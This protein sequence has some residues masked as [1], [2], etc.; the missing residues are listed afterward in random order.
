MKDSERTEGDG[1]FVLSS[2][3]IGYL[4]V[5]ASHEAHGVAKRD[6]TREAWQS[7][8]DLGDI[9]LAP[10]GV[11]AGRVVGFGEA[12]L[13]HCLVTAT[14]A[15][16]DSDFDWHET[17][18]EDDGS[19]R[20]AALERIAYTIEVDYL[21]RDEV[22]FP[23]VFTPDMEGLV[24]RLAVPSALVTVLGPE[25]VDFMEVELVVKAVERVSANWRQTRE[26]A[27]IVERSSSRDEVFH[28]HFTAPGIFALEARA[29]AGSSTW[30]AFERVEIGPA[31][32]AIDLELVP[33]G[34]QKQRVEV[35]GPDQALTQSWSASFF[36]PMSGAAGGSVTD[37]RP[38]I[39]LPVGSW[40]ATV[41]P[42]EWGF[43]LPFTQSIEV[44][45]E[46]E[47]LRLS[48]PKFGGR[49]TI[50]VDFR[51]SSQGSVGGRLINATGQVSQFIV[52][53]QVVSGVGPQRALKSAGSLRMEPIA[54]GVYVIELRGKSTTV[55]VNACHEVVLPMSLH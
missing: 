55:T 49:L 8:L 13:G 20:F 23:A 30:R 51:H 42:L 54:P 52:S 33:M 40:A 41:M 53:R 1:S 29:R 19:F 47:T 3:R 9:A 50:A 39:T 17:R 4:S 38:H 44:R 48:A 36:D 34:S 32:H 45:P 18:A 16:E 24:L 7:A 15:D 5:F 27:A 22:Q 11:L 31:H 43:V 46:T 2:D 25:G 12:P 28:V 35:R 26:V 37:A 6:R 21:S 10:R 14:P